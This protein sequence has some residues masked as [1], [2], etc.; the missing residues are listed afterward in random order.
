[1]NKSITD[2]LFAI[3]DTVVLEHLNDCYFQVVGNVPKW[4][5]QFYPNATSEEN[6]INIQTKF[7]F[8]E[9]FLID[10]ED[11]WHDNIA[12]RLKSGLWS[13]I[14]MSGQECHL[15]A[16]AVRLEN[17]K[18]L[19]IELLGVAYEEKQSLIQKARQNNLTYHYLLKETQKKEILLHCILHDVA[20]QLT[21]INC[22]FALLA[23]EN[24]TAKGRDR[25]EIGKRQSIKQEMLIQEILKAFS[26]EV[27]SLE[28]FT[29]DSAQA[30]DAVR[31]ARE[32]VEALLPT[33][34]LNKRILQLEPNIDMA[35]DWKVVGENS[36]LER[37]LFNLVENAFRH[38]PLGSTVTV[39]VNQDGE[40][41]LF[42][43][44]DEGPGVPE[45]ISK[46]LFQKF[47]QGREKSGKAGLGLYFCRIT[48]ERWGGSI[49]YSTRPQ[50]GSCFWFRLP[51][52][53]LQVALGA[54]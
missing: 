22:C 20:G 45:D 3:L 8:L 16:S 4:F 11:F 13:E 21:G 1:M 7:P 40:F 6:K 19:L 12:Q 14:D 35:Q 54:E 5:I 17:K 10:A 44:D 33:F 49:G 26:A 42:T 41:I 23:M 36:R 29:V 39:D 53:V 47:S 9:N 27:K 2:E 51:R 32:V 30:P 34:S 52:A 28:D 50:G 18:I 15:E 48:V 25:L 46:N 43:V 37:V 38:S 24:L 31:C